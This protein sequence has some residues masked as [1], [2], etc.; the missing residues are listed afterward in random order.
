MMNETV[1]VAQLVSSIVLRLRFLVAVLGTHDAGC[2]TN[3]SLY[4]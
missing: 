1:A 3:A 4:N 2:A